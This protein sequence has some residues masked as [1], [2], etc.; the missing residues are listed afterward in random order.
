MQKNMWSRRA[1]SKYKIHIPELIATLV[2]NKFIALALKF[3][4]VHK[5]FAFFQMSRTLHEEEAVVA[6]T[7]SGI[8]V[9]SLCAG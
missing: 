2:I 7:L 9:A 6:S 5:V 4:T 3:G 1:I 8:L